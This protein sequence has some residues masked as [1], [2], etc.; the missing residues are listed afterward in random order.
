MDMQ[1]YKKKMSIIL[2]QCTLEDFDVLHDLSIRTYY[3]TFADMNTAEDM[4]AYLIQAFE[5]SKLRNEL[6]RGI[7]KTGRYLL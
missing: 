3:E 1:R 5:I 7:N 6:F 2:R 4:E